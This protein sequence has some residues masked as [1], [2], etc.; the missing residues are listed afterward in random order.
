MSWLLHNYFL[1]AINPSTVPGTRTAPLRP[2]WPTLK[3]YKNLLKI[4]TRDASV[5]AQYKSDIYA[6]QR[7]IERWISEMK[8]DANVAVGELGWDSGSANDSLGG[9][10]D[11]RE[12]WALDKFCHELLEKGALVPISKK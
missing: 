6:V 8:V 11:P 5:A 1:P 2:L 3:R 4:T 12:K 7:D 9:R 10:D